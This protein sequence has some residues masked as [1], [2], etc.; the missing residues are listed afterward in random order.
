MKFRHS[1]MPGGEHDHCHQWHLTYL[2]MM[3][4]MGANISLEVIVRHGL[5]PRDWGKR[6][7][8]GERLEGFLLQMIFYYVECFSDQS[9]LRV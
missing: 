5:K 6:P 9:R 2:S 3:F 8:L 4:F 1:F 7:Q